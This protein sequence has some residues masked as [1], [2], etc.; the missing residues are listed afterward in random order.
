MI[1][2]NTNTNEYD[3]LMYKNIPSNLLSIETELFNTKNTKYKELH[4][5]ESTNKFIV[6]FIKALKYHYRLTLDIDDAETKKPPFRG[7]TVDKVKKKY[8]TLFWE[9]R[10]VADYYGW[11]YEFYCFQGADILRS[12]SAEVCP[13]L[14]SHKFMFPRLK[15]R[16]EERGYASHQF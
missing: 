10:Q 5:F 11:D 3:V 4:P 1:I 2:V 7:E 9:M 8:K 6:T 15:E 12:F 16:W 14:M 13:E